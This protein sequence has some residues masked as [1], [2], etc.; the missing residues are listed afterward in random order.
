MIDQ[1]RRAQMDVPVSYAHLQPLAFG[2]L[3]PASRSFAEATTIVLPVPF[4]RTTSYVTGTRNAPREILLASNQVELWDE[5]IAGDE[6]MGTIFTLPEME[7]AS[8]DIE[9]ALG[10][11]RRVARALISQNKFLVVLGGEHSVTVPVVEAFAEHQ[12]GLSVLQIDAHADLRDSYQGSRYSHACAMRRLVDR[13]PCVQ[14]GIRSLSRGEAEALPTLNTRVFYDRTMRRDVD[15]IDRVVEA[16]SPRVY[17]TIDCDGLDPAVM[18]AVGTPEPGGLSWA[19]LLGLLRAVFSRRQVVG[20]DLVEL[21]P[22]PGLVAP[23][24][25]CAKLIA[26]ILAYR[27]AGLKTAAGASAP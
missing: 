4:E 6:H 8:G 18:P 24:F 11:I 12:A 5:E 20:C 26:K 1:E 2:G 19:E 10:E 22:I 3:Q 27:L 15:W 23:T 17:V 7:I 21:C 14:V 13:V 9:S 16:L 25:L